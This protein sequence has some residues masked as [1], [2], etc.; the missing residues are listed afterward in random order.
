[1]WLL[2][3]RA[4]NPELA[5]RPPATALHLGLVVSCAAVFWLCAYGVALGGDPQMCKIQIQTFLSIL[6]V[7]YLLSVSLRG[8]TDYRALARLVVVAAC[9]K[10][11]VAIWVRHLLPPY[12]GSQEVEYTTTHG[13][14]LLAAAAV[15]I[16][17]A[18]Y[19]E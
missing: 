4:E 2:H 6:L 3:Y 13:D 18:A 9:I 11:G 15:A 5:I 17:V 19:F 8:P 14:S 7:A 16:V 12:V 10:A 1:M